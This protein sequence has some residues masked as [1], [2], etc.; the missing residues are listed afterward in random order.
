MSAKQITL[1]RLFYSERLG[2]IPMGREL[3]GGL[4]AGSQWRVFQ[5]ILS[6]SNLCFLGFFYKNMLSRPSPDCLCFII[7]I[8][9]WSLALVKVGH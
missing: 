5:Q 7:P 9:S 4:V 6:E 3:C 8:G 1:C 2:L